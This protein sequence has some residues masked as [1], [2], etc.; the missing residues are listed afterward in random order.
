M[1]RAEKRK[2]LNEINMLNEVVAIIRKYF[3]ELIKKFNNL[4]DLR[5]QSYITY[6]MKVIFIVRILRLMCEIKSMNEMTRE[7]NTE[8]AIENIA[9]IC[10]LELEEIPHC[11]TINNVFEQV[12][13]EEIEEIRK[14]II[15]RLIRGKI[16]KKFL[17]RDKYYHIIVD[18]TGL[19]TSKKK[20][21]NN[22]LVK[23]RTDKNGNKYQ[24]CSTYVLEAK[25]VVGD[26]VFSIGSEFVEN[27][28]STKF[29]IRKIKTYKKNQKIKYKRRKE[30]KKNISYAKYKQDC[31][32]KAFK[33]LTEKIKK[34]Y[35]RLRILISGD[36][37]Y[38]NKTVLEIC[39]KNNWKYLIRY[40]EGA[41]PTLY[42]EFR[43]IVKENNES[44]KAKYEFVT[45]IDYDDYK[46][47][48]MRYRETKNGKER[49]FTY[50]T[51]LPITNKNIEN[52]IFI[53]R[54][55]WKIE[56][57]GFNI[58]K[59]GIFN[60]GHLYSKNATAIKVHYLMI[61][62]SHIIRQMLEKGHIELKEEIKKRKI[63]IKEISSQIKNTLIST[64]INLAN[65]QSIQLRFDS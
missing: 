36:A 17:V 3:P 63:K 64:T 62:I 56:N 49:E 50:M 22:C 52:S 2:K 48:I 57:E 21:N 29:I 1:N 13:V 7:L 41:I 37:L 5:N 10:G 28:N 35:P 9:K 40:K 34:E 11:D 14:Y 44:K 31:E 38:A 54:K 6:Q 60:I 61:Q 30:D 24:E 43:K 53:G 65:A 47:N 55:R 26:M 27:K 59:N 42:E 25:L 32:I 19:A 46:T 51:D 4:T 15:T 12:E 45:Q 33:R 58:Q 16:I 20:Y 8:E 18:G 23:N 39:K